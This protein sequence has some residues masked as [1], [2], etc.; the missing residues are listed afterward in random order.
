MKEFINPEIEQINLESN[1][2]NAVQEEIKAAYGIDL[3]S[4]RLSYEL[5]NDIAS[6][7]FNH[8]IWAE[9]KA[10]KDVN[11]LFIKDAV[12][13]ANKV[14]KGETRLKDQVDNIFFIPFY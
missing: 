7:K 4:D 10:R 8:E 2:F 9:L 14:V 1:E 11:L 3:A 13:N 12:K 5:V 6:G